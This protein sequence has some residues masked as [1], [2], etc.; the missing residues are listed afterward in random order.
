MTKDEWFN[1]LLD[2]LTNAQK[3]RYA[4]LLLNDTPMGLNEWEVFVSE[5]GQTTKEELA[6][7]F[8]DLEL[9]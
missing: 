1:E 4:A 3:A 5:L 6:L 8:D 2:R 7:R 9:E